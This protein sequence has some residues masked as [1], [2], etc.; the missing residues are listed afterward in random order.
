MGSENFVVLE[1]YN[2]GDELMRTGHCLSHLLA[3]M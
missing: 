3:T 1:L 2:C